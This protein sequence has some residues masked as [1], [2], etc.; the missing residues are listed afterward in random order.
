MDPGFWLLPHN[1]PLIFF[2][3][4][5]INPGHAIQSY[6]LNNNFNIILPSNR[7][8]SNGLLPSDFPT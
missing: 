7:K 1:T 2:I 5:Q 4:S 8:S 6:R 3:L